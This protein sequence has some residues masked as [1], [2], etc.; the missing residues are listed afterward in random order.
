MKLKKLKAFT[1]VEILLVLAVSI[2]LIISSFYVWTKVHNKNLVNS[3]ATN[4]MSIKSSIVELP[5][6]TT[7]TPALLIKLGDI[8]SNRIG[9]SDNILD[10]WK[11]NISVSTDDNYYISYT[12]L[13]NFSCI[14]LAAAAKNEFNSMSIN[15]KLLHDPSMPTIISNCNQ[16]YSNTLAFSDSLTS[17][18]SYNKFNTGIVFHGFQDYGGSHK[19]GNK[20]PGLVVYLDSNNAISI[21]ND[22]GNM[23]NNNALASYVYDKIRSKFDTVIQNKYNT[24][25]GV[26]GNSASCGSITADDFLNALASAPAELWANTTVDID[27]ADSR[28]CESS[29]FTCSNGTNSNGASIIKVSKK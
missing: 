8:P 15:S 13:S 11:N 16:E 21:L 14:N 26:A 25:C 24:S 28:I 18:D 27:I 22:N 9:S 3:E 2:I 12:S 17:T 20:T 23:N 1:L 5:S 4:L 7:V 10:S 6:K 29:S 19:N